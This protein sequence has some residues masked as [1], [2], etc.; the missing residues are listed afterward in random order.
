MP[1][2][3]DLIKETELHPGSPHR[4]K[5]VW[6]ACRLCGRERWVRWKKGN[7]EYNRC[8]SLE[9]RRTFLKGTHRVNRVGRTLDAR[10]YI[11]VWVD[12]NDFFSS[13]RRSNGYIYEHRLVMAKH[14]G[15]SLQKWE[16]V[17]HKDGDKH[18]NDIDNL[19]LTTSG[20]HTIAH[21]KGYKDGFMKGY[22]EGKKKAMAE[23]QK[24]GVIE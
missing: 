10:G 19:E 4:R 2:I 24:E 14:L 12:E 13:M 1:Q 16:H 3:G 5:F 17:H 8:D 22:L 7:P 18:N 23:L 21:N 15:R 6:T 20:A 9:C 11:L